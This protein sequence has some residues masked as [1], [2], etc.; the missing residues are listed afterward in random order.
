MEFEHVANDQPLNFEDHQEEIMDEF[1][2]SDVDNSE[3][4]FVEN[5]REEIINQSVEDMRNLHPN[6]ACTVTDAFCMVY[7]YAIRHKLSWTATEDLMRLINRIIGRNELPTS[8]DTFKKK[9]RKMGNM[10]MTKHF[11]CHEC[12]LYLGSADDIKESNIQVCA[13]CQTKIQT[14]TKYKKNHFITI[15]LKNNLRNILERNSDNLNIDYHPPNINICDI[16]DSL[17]YQNTV[18]KMNNSK[19]VSLTFSADGAIVHKSS[20]EKSLWPLQFIINEISIDQRFK[21]EN[22][23]CSAVSYGKTPNMQ[24][25]FKPFIDEIN[26]INSDGGLLFKM[27]NGETEIVKIVPMIFTGDTPA[28]SHVLNKVNFNGYMGCPYCMHQGTIINKQIRYCKRDE[29][30]IRENEQSRAEMI[31]A[32]INNEKFHGYHGVSPL[33]A[34][35]NFDVVWQVGIDKMHNVDLGVTRLL[36][37]LFLDNKYRDKRYI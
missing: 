28:K 27:K 18:N 25:F 1:E 11:V 29:G 15:P 10:D 14:D 9:I 20:K 22:I 26:Q 16:H 19:F 8:S 4:E 37:R 23:F 36:F 34:F 6:T 33:I 21:K 35:K 5:H 17:Y 30:L 3:F 31:Q 13:T 2:Y 12:G 32:Q 24:I 7:A